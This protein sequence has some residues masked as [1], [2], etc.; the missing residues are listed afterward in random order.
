MDMTTKEQE[1][2]AIEKIDKIVEGLGANS[3]VAAAMEGVLELAEQNIEDDAMYSWKDRAESAQ[4][5]IQEL[6]AALKSARKEL[7]EAQEDMKEMQQELTDRRKE[8]IRLRM[9]HGQAEDLI[10]IVRT[11]QALNEE[12]AIN[13]ASSMAYAVVN[14][15]DAKDFAQRWNDAQEKVYRCKELDTMLQKYME[16]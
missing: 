13:A 10:E 15:E 2:Q 8:C 11:Q 9:N 16:E 14:G 4:K 7:Q 5:K 3:Y 6:E 12:K 1:R